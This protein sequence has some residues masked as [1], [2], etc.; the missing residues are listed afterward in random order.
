MFIGGEVVKVIPND[1]DISL[2]FIPIAALIIILIFISIIFV[3][4]LRFVPMAFK[5]TIFSMAMLGGLILW[6]KMY[7]TF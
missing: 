5:K 7:L 3:I 4:V 2:L 6:A 1:I